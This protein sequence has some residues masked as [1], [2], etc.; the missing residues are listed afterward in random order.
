MFK[1]N[2]FIRKTSKRL[3]DK[4]YDM[5]YNV[6]PNIIP[7]AGI[8]TMSSNALIL[9]LPIDNS[10][11]VYGI[12]CA[13]NEEVFLGISAINDLN[14][15]MQWF[16]LDADPPYTE[17]GGR[18]VQC[19]KENFYDEHITSFYGKFRKATPQE[20]IDHLGAVNKQ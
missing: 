2:C 10:E 9:Q 16:I 13:D 14:D 1:H 3:I 8:A 18:M 4:L 20:I 7:G 17:M 5:G 6:T 11:G 12:D 15:Y 19:T